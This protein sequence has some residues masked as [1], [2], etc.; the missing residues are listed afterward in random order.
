MGSEFAIVFDDDSSGAPSFLMWDFPISRLFLVFIFF[1]IKEGSDGRITL[2]RS[3]QFEIW[4]GRR[5]HH[6]MCFGLFFYI[7]SFIVVLEYDREDERR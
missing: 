3:V 1:Q 2:L 7:L 6:S 5:I 4:A